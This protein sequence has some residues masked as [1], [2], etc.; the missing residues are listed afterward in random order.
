MPTK[1]VPEARVRDTLSTIQRYNQC[2][3]LMSGSSLEPKTVTSEYFSSI[4][5]L[6][7]LGMQF[8]YSLVPRTLVQYTQLQCAQKKNYGAHNI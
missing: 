4:E 8:K 3:K 1:N 7:S 5:T 6:R 2:D